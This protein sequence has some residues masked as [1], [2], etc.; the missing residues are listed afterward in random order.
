MYNKAFGQ[1]KGRLNL[2]V[3]FYKNLSMHH[4]ASLVKE[5]CYETLGEFLNIKRADIHFKEF[6]VDVDRLGDYQLEGCALIHIA[7][8]GYESEILQG[9]P[10]YLNK[11]VVL[12]IESSTRSPDFCHTFL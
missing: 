3:P 7:A 12:L 2:Y 8:E 4:T 6:Q 9:M 5:E 11:A 1:E 10:S